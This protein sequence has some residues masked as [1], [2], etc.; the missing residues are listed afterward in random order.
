LAPDW[1]LDI[2]C[3]GRTTT[4]LRRQKNQ[5]PGTRPGCEYLFGLRF[6][7]VRVKWLGLARAINAH[8]E[9]SRELASTPPRYGA[10]VW[11]VNADGLKHVNRQTGPLNS[12]TFSQFHFFCFLFAHRL[13]MFLRH[14]VV[15]ACDRLEPPSRP[16]ATAAGFLRG[17]IMRC[18]DGPAIECL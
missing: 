1:R 12:I 14:A 10:G 5:K 9:A 15:L 7:Q 2:G 18:C 4:F 17:F 13:R 8:A 11:S 3:S 6:P 16:S